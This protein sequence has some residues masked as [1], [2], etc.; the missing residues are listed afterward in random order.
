[1]PQTAR[2][3][4]ISLSIE[5]DLDQR[6]EKWKTIQPKVGQTIAEIAAGFGNPEDADQ[7]RL[8]NGVRGVN[9][10]LRLK[11][12]KKKSNETT[13]D[14]KARMAKWRKRKSYDRIQVPG[15]F[16]E[17]SVL[18]V[19]G[20]AAAPTVTNGYAK[21]TTIDRPEPVRRGCGRSATDHHGVDD[22]GQR[23]RCSVHDP[24][25]VPGVQRQQGRSAL[26]D[27]RP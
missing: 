1:M 16:T 8:K 6:F 22:R 19:L 7:I 2:G 10:A 13:K 17:D 4:L 14:F 24:A 20:G 27:R 12:P 15:N 5:K 25:V 23:Q 21:F 3:Q 9:Y 11:K 18:H 26:A